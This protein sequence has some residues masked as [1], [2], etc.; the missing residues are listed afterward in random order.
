[1]GEAAEKLIDMGVNTMQK[2]LLLK[3][4]VEYEAAD[5]DLKKKRDEFKHR[6]DACSRKQATLLNK[7]TAFKSR[8]GKFERFISENELKRRRAI[9]KFYAESKA[10]EGKAKELDLLAD[11]CHITK[12]EQV[13]LSERLAE[14]KK[15][16]QFLVK[17]IEALPP[18]KCPSSYRRSTSINRHVFPQITSKQPTT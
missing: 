2:T 5:D 17:V 18:S 1:M 11:E 12:S 15:F 16:E 6:M 14:Y 3:Q 13:K 10:K 4:M 7:Q 9:Q 8:V